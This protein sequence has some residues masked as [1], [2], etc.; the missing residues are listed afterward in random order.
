MWRSTFFPPTIFRRY[1]RLK[2]MNRT[3]LAIQTHPGELNWAGR[4]T[5]HELIS[6]TLVRLMQCLT[7]G[8]ALI[9]QLLYGFRMIMKRQIWDEQV[10]AP[11]LICL[12]IIRFISGSLTSSNNCYFSLRRKCFQ[13]K[14]VF[15]S[16]IFLM[17]IKQ[18]HDCMPSDRSD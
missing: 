3:C 15:T 10:D 4:R 6:L 5:F 9:L 12:I 13:S 11:L 7:F 14:H 1:I 17:R 18:L 2:Q 8:L 16:K